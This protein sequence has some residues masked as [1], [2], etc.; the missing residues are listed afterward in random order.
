LS[1]RTSGSH[2]RVSGKYSR[3][4]GVPVDPGANTDIAVFSGSALASTLT[5]SDTD[6]TSRVMSTVVV[7]SAVTGMWLIS[8]NLKPG[9]DARSE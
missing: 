9:D 6:P 5:V 7:L 8:Y 1:V 4:L 3:T 2:S